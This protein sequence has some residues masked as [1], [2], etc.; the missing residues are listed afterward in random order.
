MLTPCHSRA[1]STVAALS[2]LLALLS[3]PTANAQLCACEEEQVMHFPGALYYDLAANAVD[4]SGDVALVNNYRDNTN[5]GAVM[6]YRFDGVSWN[7]EQKLTASDGAA[8]ELFG[9]SLAVHGDRVVIGSFSGG[10]GAAYIFEFDGAQWVEVQKISAPAPASGAF[11]GRVDLDANRLVV[12]DPF[13]DNGGVDSSGAVH[14]YLHDGTQ[15]VEEQRIASGAPSQDEYYGYSISIDDDVLVAC[16]FSY[17][18]VLLVV[19]VCA[20][21]A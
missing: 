15:W 6:V 14:T 21:A 18:G 2:L 11:S 12:S 7:E 13:A 20:A 10:I 19:C 4:V 3:A 16:R 5:Q 8:N 9:S 1:R 17:P